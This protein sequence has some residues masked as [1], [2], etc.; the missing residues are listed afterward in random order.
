MDLA[1]E[2][3][4][5]V[6][7]RLAERALREEVERLAQRFGFRYSIQVLPIS[8]AALMTP[9]WIAPR[10]EAPP[11]ATL[12]IIPG[13]A[14]GDLGPIQAAVPI[15]VCHGPKD[16]RE[17]SEFFGVSRQGVSLDAY[18]I[19]IIAEIN[20]APDIPP[21]RL[22]AEALALRQSGA[23]VIDLGCNP[24]A[25]WHEVDEAVRRLLE[26]GLQVSI[27]SFNPEEVRR[28]AAAGAELVLSVNSSNV[29]AAAEWGIEVVVVPDDPQRWEA[30]ESTLEILDRA[31]VPFR[32]DLILEPIGFGFA[33]SLLRY[34]AARQRWPQAAMMMG[35]GNL[36]ELSD[37]DSAGLNFMLLAL[38]QEWQI[39]SVL[40]TQVI[41]WARSSVRECDLAR[42]M[43]RH[44][45]EQR[46]PPKRLSEDLV[47][48]RDPRMREFSAEIIEQMASEIRDANYRIMNAAGLT[49]VLGHGDRVSGSDPFEIFDRLV[50]L[51]PKGIDPSHAF[52]LGYELCKA[53]LARLLGKQYSQDEPLRWGFLTPS[54]EPK[55]RLSRRRHRD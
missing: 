50:E 5:F 21:E 48:L 29:H 10:L 27:D 33:A 15:P 41:N 23:D 7:G 38:C 34:Q 19:Q 26:S 18:D 40:T 24:G 22:L 28:A 53:E 12:V 4:H 37:V 52:Y 17:L 51:A 3:I 25:T 11:D 49:H 1:S 16:L 30:M 8:V 13:Y 31:R 14:L 54:L 55:H 46:V 9:Q 6:T 43:V 39:D 47:M 32:I 2:V 20:H 44:A 35:I 42:R 45:I 36:T